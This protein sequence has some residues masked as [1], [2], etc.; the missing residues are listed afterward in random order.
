VASWELPVSVL[1]QARVVA[2]AIRDHITALGGRT[3]RIEPEELLTGRAA[4]LGL[5]PPTRISSGG[6]S[7]LIAAAD[8]W[9]GLTLSRA[10]DREA[11]PALLESP[12]AEADPWGS[13]TA[14]AVNRQ[15]AGIVARARLL[16]LPAAV[17]GEI[18]AG[19]PDIVRHAAQSTRP[20]AELL[21]ADL[22]SMWAGPL[23]GRLLAAAGATVV[24]VE[25]PARPDGTRGG[26]RRFFD[27]MNSGKLSYSVDFDSEDVFRLLQAADVVIE[28]S[29]P[30]ALA[31][32]GLSATK[33]SARPGRVWLRVSGY[34]GAQPDWVAFGDDAAVAGGL[35]SF[36]HTGPVFCGDAIADPLTGLAAT[37]AVLDAL[38]SGGGVVIDVAMAATAAAYAGDGPFETVQTHA[39]TLPSSPAH[40]LGADSGRV[41][42][43][44]ESRLAAC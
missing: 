34:G 27:W 8:G 13:L 37:S 25:T 41:R 19:E 4:L 31:R 39:P 9:F 35:V 1:S 36:G 22:S 6:A 24:K 11:L 42:E 18:A 29:R 2:A 14:A 15:A 10:D 7:R 12:G 43:L 33:I 30:A 26:D 5:E 28:G 38:A 23:C 16:G 20:I 40:E 32:R 44:I 3:V 17:L 21:V